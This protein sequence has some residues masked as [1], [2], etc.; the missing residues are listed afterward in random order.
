ME[1]LV[2]GASYTNLDTDALLRLTDWARADG[3]YSRLQASHLAS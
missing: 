1:R 2:C 3:A